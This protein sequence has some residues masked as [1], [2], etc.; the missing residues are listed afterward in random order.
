MSITNFASSMLNMFEATTKRSIASFSALE[1]ADGQHTF[2]AKDGSMAT[3]LKIDGINQLASD[4]SIAK[5][6]DQMQTRLS[7]YFI[8]EGHAIQF[9]FARDVSQSAN[10][11]KNLV[12]P[13]RQVAKELELDLADLLSEREKFLSNYM[14][15]DGCYI[16]LWTRLSILT[17]KEIKTVRAE[18]SPPKHFP[19]LADAQDPFRLSQI[20]YDRHQAF[21]QNFLADLTEVNVRAKL[22]GVHDAL[23]VM[24]YSVYPDLVG[25]NWRGTLPGDQIKFRS[26]EVNDY[27]I[28]HVLW[29][30]IEDQI[31]DREAELVNPR[32]I[33]VGDYVFSSLDLVVGPQKS[34]PFSTLLSRIQSLGEFP[35]RISYLID[36]GGLQFLGVKS[37]LSSVFQMTNFENR[38]I[39]EAIEELQET[40]QQG[41]SIVKCRV[42]L[43]TWTSKDNVR[44]VEEQVLKLQRNVESWGF[45]KLSS[46]IG[47]PLAAKMSST[48]GLDSSS[49]APAGAVPL[50]EVL[51]ILPWERDASPWEEGSV[52]FRTPDGRPWPYQPGSSLQNSF[53]DLIFSPPGRGKSVF[54]NSV[55]L[56]YCLSPT[57][58][59]SL[60]NT[61]LPRMAIIDI[62]PSSAGLISILQESL[63]SNR[64]HE[65]A[66]HRLQMTKDYAINPFDTQL[67]CRYPLP[68]DKAFLVNFVIALSTDVGEENP[69]SG[70]MGIINTAID[71]MYQQFDDGH[72]KGVPKIYHANISVEIDNAIAE[73]GLELES[74]ISTWW[75]VVDSFFSH[76]DIHMATL[77]QR[78]AVP[79]LEDIMTILRNPQLSDIHGDAMTNAGESVIDVCTRVISSAIRE[80]PILQQ[81]TAFDIGDSRIVALDLDE[82]TYKGG[83]TA[84]K[85][86]GLMYMLAR[87]VLAND[88]FLNK[89]IISSI[90]PKYRNWHQM[91]IER[92]GES[93]KRLV[94]DEFHRTSNVPMVRKQVLV[95]MRE[96][97]KWG[98]QITLV[99][100]LL[101]DFSNEMIDMAS[102]C[103]LLGIGSDRAASEVTQMFGLSSTAEKILI[104]E[105]NGPG[106]FGTPMLAIL[107][108]KE[109]RH[110]HLLY[111]TLSPGEVWALS[112][113]AEDVALRQKLYDSLRPTEARRRLA[114]K[115]PSGS[116]KQ[117]IERRTAKLMS[118]EG[119]EF[120]LAG[121]I[122][123]SLATEIIDSR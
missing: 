47:D 48:L 99:S 68:T 95:D 43:S 77:A 13:A 67:G 15:W 123:E 111:L 2:V 9:W 114:T 72:R 96:G 16:V 49:T 31:F 1:T 61:K 112:T 86:T 10:L 62:G 75:E 113:T 46:H 108:L 102:G 50:S 122:I 18:I 41:D 29:P 7:P 20:L 11:V 42:S 117:E 3:V 60:D 85:Q 84:D 5:L 121:S 78:Y 36:G 94:Y 116:A 92:I 93:S 66:Y 22:M 37:F 64:R 25:C 106:K 56:A 101:G 58:V 87:F 35:W 17:K 39:R 63:P 52:L 120:H 53:V 98:V 40:R 76:D 21:S 110:E 28:S 38:Q 4:A 83:G 57:A 107:E 79:I 34:E 118:H 89:E 91:R 24:R 59:A 90:S 12:Y 97:R 6:V 32:V 82:V 8:G 26:P 33:R 100:Q 55:N 65:V 14:T 19:S 51:A 45:C 69:P 27:D 23:N 71:L 44:L 54:L 81:P 30:R 73:N 70:L 105:L 74:G 88:F 109:G 80:I 104:S 115:F 119:H 103:W